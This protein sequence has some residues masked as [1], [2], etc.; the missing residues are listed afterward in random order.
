MLWNRSYTVWDWRDC[1]LKTFLHLGVW[2]KRQIR[3]CFWWGKTL[4]HT[5]SSSG[6]ESQPQWTGGNAPHLWSPNP[7][8]KG[9]DDC[10]S[11]MGDG[12][13]KAKG[14]LKWKT[15]GTH[16][17]IYLLFHQLSTAGTRSGSY[18]C[19][20]LYLFCLFSLS[21]NSLLEFLS[22]LKLNGLRVC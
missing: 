21:S 9:W 19:S 4:P 3:P 2:G 18:V 8:P 14:C 22:N 12:A 10:K 6:L 17:L 13:R 20:F 5:P 16:V 15:R 1:W 7:A 11:L